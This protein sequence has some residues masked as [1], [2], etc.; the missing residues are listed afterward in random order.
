MLPIKVQVNWPFGLGEEVN[1]RFSSQLAFRLKEK[2]RKID[3][4]DGQPSWI[5]DRNDFS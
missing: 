5:S 4:Q 3:F 2:N 1:N